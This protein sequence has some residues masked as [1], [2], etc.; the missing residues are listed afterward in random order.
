MRRAVGIGHD[1]WPS[2]GSGMRVLPGRSQTMVDPQKLQIR[3]CYIGGG[4]SA[5]L[6]LECFW[7]ER[8][9]SKNLKELCIQDFDRIG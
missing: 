7:P 3:D 4:A 9:L 5:Q 2:S 1:N 6:Q 8:N